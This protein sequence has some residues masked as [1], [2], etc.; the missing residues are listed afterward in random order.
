[1]KKVLLV[2]LLV[3]SLSSEAIGQSHNQGAAAGS[4]GTQILGHT[5]DGTLAINTSGAWGKF[6]V[7][8]KGGIFTHNSDPSS[9]LSQSVIPLSPNV[10]YNGG[11]QSLIG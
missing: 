8:T 11:S 1:M 3:L 6:A 7:S 10:G 5:T 2:L 9:G 4:M